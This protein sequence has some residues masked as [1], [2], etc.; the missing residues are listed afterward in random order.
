M[1]RRGKK[2]VAQTPAPKKDRIYGSERNPKG[3][4]SSSKSA[5]KIELSES[6][7]NTLENKRDEYNAKH[8]SGK[9]TL[10][11]LKAVFRRGAGAYSSSHRPTITGGRPN[12]RSAWAFARVNKFLLKKG[13]TK[14][15]AA[16]VQDDDLMEMGGIIA[17][18]GNNSNLTPEQYKLVRTPEFKAWFGDWENDPKNASKVVDENG[19]PLVVYHGTTKNFNI[20]EKADKLREDWDVRDYGMY[21]SSSKNTAKWYSLDYTKKLSSFEKYESDLEEAKKNQDWDNYLKIREQNKKHDFDLTEQFESIIILECFLNIRNPLL[22]DAHGKEWFKVL[23]GAVDE[24]LYLGANGIIVKNVVEI[25]NEIQTT[26]IAFEPNQIKLADGSN[27]TFDDNN[28]DIR[29]DDGGLVNAL[30]GGMENLNKNGIV[31]SDNRGDITVIAYN[32]GNQEISSSLYNKALIYKSVQPIKSANEIMQNFDLQD[33][34]R[35]KESKIK[36]YK[37]SHLIV[38]NQNEVVYDS[39]V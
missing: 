18:N 14:V 1:E 12:S 21:F 38:L 30:N 29:Y 5:S 24:A 3:S 25:G 2:S 31:L 15:K 26:Y 19:E 17:P 37:K 9:V 10:A 8:P 13:G 22:I 6:I 4:A 39:N 35:F 27:T 32:T 36:D 34:E 20:F 11:T 28:P 16:Y 7:I 23:V 33:F